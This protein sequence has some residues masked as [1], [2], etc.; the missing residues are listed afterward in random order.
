[1]NDWIIR[2]IDVHFSYPLWNARKVDFGAA[3]VC[4]GVEIKVR[5]G[6][7]PK[8]TQLEHGD[9]AKKHGF[10]GIEIAD[11]WW[12]SWFWILIVRNSGRYRELVDGVI[13]QLT[14]VAPHCTLWLVNIAM[15]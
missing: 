13:H 1:M 4:L 3:W 10:H 8:K 9:L 14:K 2:Y 7:A 12:L 11:L 5:S 15:G 6:A